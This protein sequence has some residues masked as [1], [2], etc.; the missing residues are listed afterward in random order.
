[1]WTAST[2]LECARMWTMSTSDRG[3]GYDAPV[4]S[5][6]HGNLREALVQAAV[7][8]GRE[9]GPDGIVIREVA[10]RTGVSHNAAYRHFAD[11]EDLLREVSMVGMDELSAAMLRRVKRV[12]VTEP[13]E[14]ARR[15]LRELGKA[16]VEYAIAEPGLFAVAFNP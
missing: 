5:Y 1:M 8:L 13:V 14:R 6:H 3:C 4:T 15:R 11:R 12:R 10:R 2:S 7:E 9:K 16:Y